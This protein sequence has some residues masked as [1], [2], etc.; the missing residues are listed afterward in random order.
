MRF[1]QAVK[2]GDAAGGD[3]SGTFPSPTVS[4][5][6]GRTVASAAPSSGQVL[7]WD[8]TQWAPAAAGGGGDHGT[9]SG[10]A[11]DDH[12]QY[13]LAD[14]ART[15]TNG[16]AVTGT[17][18]SGSIPTTGGSARLMW[19]PRKAAF[20]AGQPLSTQWDDANIGNYSTAMGFNGTASG[21]GSTAM[22]YGTTAS[23]DFSTAMGSGTTASGG[24]STA[25]GFN[26]AASGHYTTAM[27]RYA[28]TNGHVGSFVYGDAS[29]LNWLTALAPNT[30]TVRAAGGTVFYSNA[31]L[32]SGVVLAA[33]AGGWSSVSDAAMKENWRDLDGERVLNE[34]AA[35]EVREWNYIS[36][37]ASI[38]HVGPTAQDFHAAF[39]LGEDPLK[40][41]TVDID[42]I[43]MVAIQALERRSD[44][45]RTLIAE[46]ETLIREQSR[47]IRSIEA[48]LQALEARLAAAGTAATRVPEGGS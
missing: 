28:S 9:L 25:L 47:L 4:R 19:Y 40:I 39:G 5:L 44:Q 42:G 10:L 45:L 36:Q 6:Q 46:Q 38:R 20:R 16:F 30:F 1:E 24:Y 43:N 8:G 41:N 35:M 18:G 11:D 31:G 32:T 33:G 34:V 21:V 3:L 22:G 48:R 29:T 2:G 23:G 27:G 13:I 14:G 7:A 17:F 15:T 26:T 12:S 37:D